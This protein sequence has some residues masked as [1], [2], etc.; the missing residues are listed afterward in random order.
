MY[1]GTYI[2]YSVV[3]LSICKYDKD[4]YY[5]YVENEILF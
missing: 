5:T 4:Y 2:T 3:Q 1:V